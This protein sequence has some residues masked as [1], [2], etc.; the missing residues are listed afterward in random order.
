MRKA[1]HGYR[2]YE[3]RDGIRIDCFKR[4]VSRY[5][6]AKCRIFDLC[7]DIRLK[8]LEK[9]YFEVWDGIEAVSRVIVDADG[10]Y[11]EVPYLLPALTG[12]EQMGIDK[13]Y[14]LA[15]RNRLKQQKVGHVRGDMTSWIKQGAG[16]KEL[17]HIVGKD[18][19]VPGTKTLTRTF[20]RL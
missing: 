19:Y 9:R 17:C 13:D 15:T 6:V 2:I 3:N 18:E 20:G 14:M 1:T 12:R 8:H 16:E 5:E 10:A 4:S 7:R 11:V